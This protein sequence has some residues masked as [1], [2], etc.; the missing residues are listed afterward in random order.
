[1]TFSISPFTDY[2][3]S[4]TGVGDISRYQLT[5]LYRLKEWQ[6]HAMLETNTIL[7]MR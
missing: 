6:I 7:L 4:G 3:K 2:F 5:V 1:M